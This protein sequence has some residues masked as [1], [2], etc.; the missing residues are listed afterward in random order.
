MAHTKSVLYYSL[1]SA[2]IMMPWDSYSAMKI[3]NKS[4]SYA[5]AYNQVNEVRAAVAAPEVSSAHSDDL[6]VAGKTED[7]SI[8][9]DLPI[10][11]ANQTLALQIARGESPTVTVEQLS[12][13]GAVY[14][15]GEFVWDVPTAGTRSGANSQCTSVIE[16][17]G[18]QMGAGGSDLVLARVNVAAGD[19]VQCNISAW[20]EHSYLPAAGTIEFPNDAE[21]T[22]EDV[23][24]VMNQE[25]KQHAG[26]K[27]AAGAVLAAVAGNALGAKE[28]GKDSLLGTNKEKL[29]STAIGAATGAAIMAGN[30][31][32][33]KVAGDMILSAGVNAAAGGLIGNMAASGDS[34]L[35]IELCEYKA[36]NKDVEAASDVG[37]VETA[38]GEA[39]ASDAGSE[40]KSLG[41]K[42]NKAEKNKKEGKDKSSTGQKCLWGVLLKR[43]EP[44]Y[45]TK[46]YFYDV[47]DED[48]YLCDKAEGFKKCEL[49]KKETADILLEGYATV[50]GSDNYTGTLKDT[51]DEEYDL[52]KMASEQYS[53]VPTSYSIKET[54]G[55]DSV[56]QKAMEPSSGAP[57]PKGDNRFVK[58]IKF[59]IVE[60]TE[61]AMLVGVTD[62][63][64]GWKKKDYNEFLSQHPKAKLMGRGNDGQPVALSGVVSINDFKPMY[65]DAEDGALIDLGNKARLKGTLIGAGAGGALGAFTAYQGAQDDIQQR[66]VTAVREYKDSLQKVYCA[67]GT[68]FLTHYNDM[69]IIPGASE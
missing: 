11:V 54:P 40:G 37:P 12:K 7:S 59:S 48:V 16:M 46:A 29:Q 35:K 65:Q 69:V 8:V 53:K 32:G 28:V 49:L 22:V 55:S 17:R 50:D 52:Q 1:L 42:K 66:W 47:A 34:V 13:C 2:L 21:P 26:I 18:Y 41:G 15:N 62:K 38:E 44:D 60:S 58:I 67:T 45:N 56:V 6:G 5:D 68:R 19:S 9:A 27:I 57:N 30:V 10:R 25:Q 51:K 33:G 36:D 24:Q 61:P 23:I 4:R 3:S 14:P 31:Y 39:A 43:T 20:P 64:F 63:P